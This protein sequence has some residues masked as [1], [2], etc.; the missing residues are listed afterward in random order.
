MRL[1]PMPKNMTVSELTHNERVGERG[2]ALVS[3]LMISLLLLSAGGALILTSAMSVTNSVDSTAETQAYYA[4]QSGLQS[5]LN[6]LRGNVA[7]NP[8][9]DTSSS[10]ADA[11]KITFRKAVTASTS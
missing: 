11:N 9:F 4:A 8:L 2:A 5:T 7:P 1:S 10:T 3:V 6:V